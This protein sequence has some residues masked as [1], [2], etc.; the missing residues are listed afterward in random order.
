[1][2]HFLSLIVFS[3]CVRVFLVVYSE[4]HDAWYSTVKYTDVDYR[5]FSDAGRFVLEGK[6][7]FLRATYRYTPLLAWLM[8]VCLLVHKAAGKLM[9]CL[10]DMVNGY[11][12]YLIILRMKRRK[13]K[14]NK[15]FANGSNIAE[16]GVL[17]YLLNPMVVSISTRGNGDAIALNLVFLT[18]YYLFEKQY[19]K[20][21]FFYALS[22]HV[23]LF[24]VVYGFL[25]GF[26]LLFNS[27]KGRNSTTKMV[28]IIWLKCMCTFFV[29]SVVL[30]LFLYNLY[31]DVFLEEAFLYHL[32]RIDHRHN[33]SIWFYSL[34]LESSCTNCD[35]DD[36]FI[37]YV[38]PQI[39]LLFFVSFKFGFTANGA[40]TLLP[41]NISI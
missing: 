39:L 10:F 8:S 41:K 34:Y 19:V 23:R 26:Y 9:F 27:E 20:F 28:F 16:W 11:L 30:I 36:G 22:V 7:P 4:Y 2:K 31:G 15:G 35:G 12:L 38:L 13:G 29:V 25:F 18:V 1:M 24:P 40:K 5:V 37:I 14:R 32:K 6:S 17:F 33:F 21:A 3:F